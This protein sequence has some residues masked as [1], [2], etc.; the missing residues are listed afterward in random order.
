MNRSKRQ[1][2]SWDQEFKPTVEHLRVDLKGWGNRGEDPSSAELFLLCLALGFST[3]TLRD[4]PARKTDGPRID[5]FQPEQMALIKAVALSEAEAADILI[6][7]DRV[8]DIVERYAAGGLMLL[9]QARDS[10]PNF[11]DW[12]RGKLLEYS[13][14]NSELE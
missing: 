12:L 10:Q 9:T 5:Y 13:K 7:E 1:G 11:K 6:D 8:Y 3:G 14:L 2:F 4:V